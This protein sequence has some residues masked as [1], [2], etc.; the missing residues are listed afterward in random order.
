MGSDY[1]RRGSKQELYLNTDEV[2]SPVEGEQT[3]SPEQG[4]MTAFDSLVL[5]NNK[6]K[7]YNDRKHSLESNDRREWS[8]SD[9]KRPTSKE[10]QEELFKTELCNAWINGQRCR[11]GKRCMFA[12]G[13]HELRAPQRKLDRMRQRPPLKRQIQTILSK[14]N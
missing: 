6:Q 5:N 4:L 12:H 14:I 13:Q 2:Q 9:K 7:N 3:G 10:R 11:F 1:S 8:R